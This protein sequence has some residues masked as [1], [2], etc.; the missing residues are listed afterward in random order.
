MQHPRLTRSPSA[1]ILGPIS[2]FLTDP[3]AQQNANAETLGSAL[4]NDD[5][6]DAWSTLYKVN[7]FSIY[8]MTT[9][10][11]GLLDK[12]TQ[13]I[14]GYTSSVVNITSISGI[15]KIAQGHV[16]TFLPASLGGDRQREVRI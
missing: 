14:E 4:F 10:F 15:L 3:G 8:Y 7:T 2:P 6:P 12:G 9:A 16:S 11:L 1:G 13:D 5:G